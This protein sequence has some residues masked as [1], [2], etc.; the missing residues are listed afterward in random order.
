MRRSHARTLT[1]VRR[2]SETKKETKKET[3][4]ETKREKRDGKRR[5][6]K[7]RTGEKDGLA[8]E[9]RRLVVD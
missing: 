8:D 9:K 1:G 6:D 2:A 5:F 3:K 4:R 7:F